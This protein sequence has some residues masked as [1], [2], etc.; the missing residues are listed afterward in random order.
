MPASQ[1]IDTASNP[2]FATLSHELRTPLNGLLGISQMLN[3]EREDEDI[4]AIEGCARHMLAVLHTLVN[5]SKIQAEWED[6]PEYREWVNV[7]ELTEQLKKNLQFRAQLR[8][9][10]LEIEHQDKSLRIRGDWDHYRTILENALLGSIEGV[11]L[12][13]VPTELQPMRLKWAAQ[14]SDVLISITNPLEEFDPKAKQKINDAFRMTTGGSHA[15]INMQY[16]YGAVATALL[17]KHNGVLL[18]SELDGGAVQTKL[19]FE[20]EQMQASESSNLP[21]GGLSLNTRAPSGKNSLKIPVQLSV[22]V[23]EDDPIARS[24]MESVLK[25]MGQDVTFA[26]NGREVLEHISQ[27]KFDVIL[28]DIDM[29]L[30]DG[31]SAAIALRNG[32]AG[33]LGSHIPIVAVTAFSTL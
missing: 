2:L 21:V 18:T 1:Q 31:V 23:A 24:L 14:G 30:M 26:L 27:S 29:P 15:R 3:E 13:K 32:E 28:M 25:H 11:N 10:D 22:L 16:L 33:E 8:G 6:L 17:E 12:S 19:S 4:Q 7:F 20:A 9:L 5:L